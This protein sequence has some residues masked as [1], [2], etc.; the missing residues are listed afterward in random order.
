MSL[1]PVPAARRTRVKFCGLVREQDVAVAAEVGA[2]ALGLVFY[3]KSPRFLTLDEAWALRRAWPSWVAAV[4]LFVNAE[5]ERVLAHSRRLG[6]DVLQFHGDETHAT[7]SASLLGQQPYWRA[8]RMRTA[9]D[10]LTSR[11]SFVDAE[12]FLLDADSAGYGGSGRRFD[13]S[14]IPAEHASRLI[15]SGGLGVDSVGQ[16]IE[17]LRPVG[18]DVSTGIQGSNPREK[19]AEKMA[20]FMAQVLDTDTRLRVRT[21]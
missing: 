4:G 16:A 3:E 17:S 8:V 19:D 15:V 9:A 2:D 10:L 11:A 7:V 21:P 12:S 1:R 13:W 14:L 20:A 5:P 18:V 6:L